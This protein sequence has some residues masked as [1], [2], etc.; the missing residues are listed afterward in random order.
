MVGYAE[1]TSIS[2]VRNYSPVEGNIFVG[3]VSGYTN[4]A[5]TIV[6]SANETGANI[7][8]TRGHV[9]GIVGYSNG[10]NIEKS[11]NKANITGYGDDG[12][13]F[14]SAGG[15]VGTKGKVYDC[16]NFGNVYAT[17]GQAGGIKGNGYQNGSNHIQRCYNI[18]TITGGN[19][20]NGSIVGENKDST[21]L[22]CFYTSSAAACGYRGSASNTRQVTDS[23]LK[24][25]GFSATN[26]GENWTD[27]I[28]NINNGY[29]ILKWQLQ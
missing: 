22:T 17:K 16:Y 15:I 1:A 6:E 26:L 5:S 19:R 23:E 25:S 28:H 13:G 21:I 20:A 8:A 9:G 18:G 27:D 10:M 29:P 14:T 4:L 11:Y 7:T 2:R 12:T 3:G 24:E